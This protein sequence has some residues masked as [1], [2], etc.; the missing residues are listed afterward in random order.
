MAKEVLYRPDILPRGAVPAEDSPKFDAAARTYCDM[1]F[2]IYFRDEPVCELGYSFENWVSQPFP[3]P[4][5]CPSPSPLS[6]H[7]LFP[8]FDFPH[9]PKRPLL[10]RSLDYRSYSA[11]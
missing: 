9:T 1:G 7:Y 8:T 11:A 6:P 5:L 2:E 4:F 10:T 3:L